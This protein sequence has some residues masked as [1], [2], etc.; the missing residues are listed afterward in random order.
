[1]KKVNEKPLLFPLP[2]AQFVALT[3]VLFL[4]R[5][6]SCFLERFQHARGIWRQAFWSFSTLTQCFS[7]FSSSPP[8]LP[9]SKPHRGYRT[10]ASNTSDGNVSE[11]WLTRARREQS[12]WSIPQ[13]RGRINLNIYF[14]SITARSRWPTLKPGKRCVSPSWVVFFYYINK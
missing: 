13:H 5:A 14:I 8:S 7:F 3:A 1:M 4:S 11:L 9:S 6:C 2:S 10:R 12:S